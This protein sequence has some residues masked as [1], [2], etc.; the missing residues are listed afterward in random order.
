MTLIDHM[1]DIICPGVPASFMLKQIML[2]SIN[3]FGN[4]KNTNYRLY[5]G[6][7][8]VLKSYY[9]IYDNQ[10]LDIFNTAITTSEF[11]IYNNLVKEYI[12]NIKKTN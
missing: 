2:N 8:S 7:T 12:E 11:D 5:E 9:S 3:G 4:L 6:F 1:N 10:L